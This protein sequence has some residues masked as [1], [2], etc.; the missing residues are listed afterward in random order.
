MAARSRA[1]ASPPR[2]NTSPNTSGSMQHLPV[3]RR[4]LLD[5]LRRRRPFVIEQLGGQFQRRAIVPAGPVN[6]LLAV[7]AA[8][9]RLVMPAMRV[10]H[11]VL[12]DVPQPEVKRH[13]RLTQ[14]FLKPATR[15]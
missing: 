4:F 6:R 9:L 14:V 15:L 11:V 7:D 10:D 3:S 8:L 12:G 5:R 1:G 13:R 2:I